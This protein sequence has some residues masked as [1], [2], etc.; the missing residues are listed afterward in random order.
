MNMW[1][2]IGIGLLI[3]VLYDLF[4]GV[5]WTTRPIYRKHEPKVYWLVTIIWIIVAVTT[6]LSGLR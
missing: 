6:T 3:W 4:Y 1:F 5:T 2:Y